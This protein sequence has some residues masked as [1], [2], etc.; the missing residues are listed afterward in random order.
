[1]VLRGEHTQ[2]VSQTLHLRLELHDLDAI[3]L[4]Q[5]AD[6]IAHL[7]HLQPQVG[8]QHDQIIQTIAQHA[9]IRAEQR[10]TVVLVK[11]GEN[12][13]QITCRIIDL[14][15]LP[16]RDGGDRR[17]REQ[18]IAVGQATMHR[19]SGERPQAVRFKNV[20]P[21]RR[22]LLRHM[23]SLTQTLDPCGQLRANL[24]RGE[25]R[26]A[27]LLQKIRTKTVYRAQRGAHAGTVVQR[28][29]RQRTRLTIMMRGDH[30]GNVSCDGPLL[31]AVGERQNAIDVEPQSAQLAVAHQR[32]RGTHATN[33]TLASLRCVR[34]ERVIQLARGV[35]HHGMINAIPLVGGVDLLAVTRASDGGVRHRRARQGGHHKSASFGH[36]SNLNTH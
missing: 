30:H 31:F 22:D 28:Q 13:R 33:E 8:T 1:M 3:G 9:S 29:Q 2:L 20:G 36:N 32:L 26:I 15:I 11:L 6:E 17:A 25:H 12:P 34:S 27:G 19:T 5:R 10:I 24:P 14:H 23:A 35:L 16:V 21:A 4:I 18:H 7:F